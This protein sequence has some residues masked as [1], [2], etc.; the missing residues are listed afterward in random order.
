MLHTKVLCYVQ[1]KYISDYQ[2]L[3]SNKPPLKTW[4]IKCTARPK[5]NRQRHWSTNQSKVQSVSWRLTPPHLKKKNLPPL[6]MVSILQLSGV[7]SVLVPVLPECPC[8]ASIS[9][10]FRSNGCSS[11]RPGTYSE[12]IIN[13]F[14]AFVRLCVDS[15][16]M[17]VCR[18]QRDDCV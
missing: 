5:G 15:K 2:P 10:F 17:I 16:E 14:L 8:Q 4:L 6:L 12:Y 7:P 18:R 9:L 13:S 1:S 3:F 11:N